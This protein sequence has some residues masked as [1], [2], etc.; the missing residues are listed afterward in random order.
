MKEIIELT[1]SPETAFA[2]FSDI[3]RNLFEWDSQGGGKKSF[4]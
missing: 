3:V 1:G 2:M 4:C